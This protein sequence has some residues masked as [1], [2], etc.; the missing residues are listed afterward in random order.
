MFRPL[1]LF[2]RARMPS[3]EGGALDPF[4]RM[5]DEFNRMFD[6]AFANFGAMARATDMRSPRIDVHETADRIN[7]EA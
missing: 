2:N 3:A 1:S 4:F 5:N 7:I 6:E